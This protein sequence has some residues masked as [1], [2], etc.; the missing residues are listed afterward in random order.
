[1]VNDVFRDAYVIPYMVNC[2]CKVNRASFTDYSKVTR[3]RKFVTAY[4]GVV[5]T[6]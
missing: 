4:T 1:M 2:A 3:V 6:N 5:E